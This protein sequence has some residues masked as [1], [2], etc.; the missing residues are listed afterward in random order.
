MGV[1]LYFEDFA[2][3]QTFTSGGKTLTEAEII[4]FAMVYDPQP[5]HIDV[6][7]A[8]AGPFGGLIASGFQTFAIAFRLFYD[9]G[10]FRDASMGSGGVDRLRWHHP[11]R[12][13][14]T[15]TVVSEVKE[16]RP[17]AS[18]PNR[19]A[20][21]IE[22]VARNQEGRTVLSYTCPHLIARRDAVA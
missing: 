21:V 19:G 22:H 15:L 8:R 17:S 5:F 4:G 16:V 20:V 1:N 11:V 9:T 6:E 2:V 12:P 10:T 13:G 18:K 3:G 14:D 7:A